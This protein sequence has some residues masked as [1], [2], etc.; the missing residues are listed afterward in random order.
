MFVLNNF[1]ITDVCAPFNMAADQI[2]CCAHVSMTGA[3]D[4]QLA[5][6]KRSCPSH[7]L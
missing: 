6:T 4:G 3:V 7:S 1:I 2:S 5:E